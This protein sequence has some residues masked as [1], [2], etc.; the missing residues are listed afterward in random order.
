MT[1]SFSFL[2]LPTN[3]VKTFL[4]SKVQLLKS[5]HGRL[6]FISCS[7]HLKLNSDLKVNFPKLR[8]L[9]SPWLLLLPYYPSHLLE[10]WVFFLT[11]T[12]LY[13]IR[14]L[15]SSNLV[16]FMWE[17]LDVSDLFLAKPLL[18]ILLLLSSILSWTIV[19]QYFWTF[20]QINLLVFCLFLILLLVL[21]QIVYS[22]ISSH[23]SYSKISAPA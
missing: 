11:L 12:C 1:F 9:L 14:I 2:P 15:S 16:F 8:T 7:I 13:P 6:Q 3:S 4:F 5:L 20:L 21:S 19:T 22:K 23:K 10:I 17:F 18:A